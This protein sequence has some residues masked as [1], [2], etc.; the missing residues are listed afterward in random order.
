MKFLIALLLLTSCVQD[1]PKEWH[2][3]RSFWLKCKG[4]DTMIVASSIETVIAIADS[5]VS[6]RQT[7]CGIHEIWITE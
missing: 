5:I 7:P 2:R 1:R 6:A 3:G 4:V